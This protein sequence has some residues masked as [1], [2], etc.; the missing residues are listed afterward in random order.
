MKKKSIAGQKIRIL[1]IDQDPDVRQIIENQ[2]IIDI[3]D[4][5][6]VQDTPVALKVAEEF[7]P[8]FVL[9]DLETVGRD[10]FEIMRKLKSIDPDVAIIALAQTRHTDEVREVLELG[11]EDFMAKPFDPSLIEI[12]MRNIREKRNLREQ[13]S[14]LRGEL[15]RDHAFGMLVGETNS[16]IALREFIE[17]VADTDLNILIRGESGTGKDVTSRL[18]HQLSGR[19]DKPFVKVNC[20]ALPDNLIES[21]LFG[22]EKGA[23]TGAVRAKPGRFQLAHGG[24]IFLDEITEIPFPL[25]SKLLQVLEQREFVT[26]G[27][28][29]TIRVD[30]RCIAATNAHMEQMMSHQRFREDLFFRLNEFSISL[31]PLRERKEDI[32]LLID[33]FLSVYSERYQR[34]RL[35]LPQETIQQMMDYPW[36]GNIR[37][38]ESLLKRVIVLDSEEIIYQTIGSRHGPRAPLLVEMKSQ[39]HF[40]PQASPPESAP[41]VLAFPM[42]PASHRVQTPPPAAVE[43]PPSETPQPF[44]ATPLKDIVEQAVEAAE[45]KTILESLDRL[46]WNRR[47]V[48]QHLGISYSSLLRRI[49]KYGLK[50]DN[51]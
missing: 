19:R 8:D 43:V 40:P 37:E 28:T 3:Y 38:L 7:N 33:Y 42:E 26:V 14:R 18:I 24:T 16:I 49:E 50:N 4:F 51:P 30:C 10:R 35:S 23:F 41:G 12:A 15:E 44:K 31:P 11:A 39:A 32:P 34:K 21:E 13:V 47:K 20:A 46:R 29:R 48:A 1:L 9:L 36:P 45:K 22:Y 17:Q 27:G 6:M 25:Q 2:G 5:E